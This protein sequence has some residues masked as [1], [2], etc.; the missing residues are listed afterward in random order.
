MKFEILYN[1]AR[2]SVKTAE[3]DAN[4]LFEA[5]TKFKEA[6]P[7]ATDWE[8]GIEIDADFDFSSTPHPS[9]FYEQDEL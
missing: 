3:I 7:N 8:I 4:C 2:G 6:Y 9:K 1:E 5:E